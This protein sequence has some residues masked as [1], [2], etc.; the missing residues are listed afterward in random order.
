MA[1]K[2][3][4]ILVF[5]D[6]R[7][8]DEHGLDTEACELGLHA[9][10]VFQGSGDIRV[11]ST[12]RSWYY[13]SALVLE[14]TAAMTYTM[15]FAIEEHKRRQGLTSRAGEATRGLISFLVENGANQLTLAV[16]LSIAPVSAECIC[17]IEEQLESLTL[18]VVQSPVVDRPLAV[19]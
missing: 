17:L 18:R 7:I 4:Q 2:I 9:P 15:R 5:C 1:I 6:M 13:E 12:N 19:G 8:N 16:L 14:T 3:Y 11:L 10:I